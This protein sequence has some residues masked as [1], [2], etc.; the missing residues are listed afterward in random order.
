[1]WHTVKSLGHGLALGAAT[2]LVLAVLAG[3]VLSLSVNGECQLD[4]GDPLLGVDPMSCV[5]PL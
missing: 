3:C 5:S 2:L 4:A 1:M